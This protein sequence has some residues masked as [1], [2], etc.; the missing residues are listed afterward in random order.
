MAALDMPRLLIARNNHLHYVFRLMSQSSLRGILNEQG[1][2][3]LPLLMCW[4][5][6]GHM[7]VVPLCMCWLVV[8]L[9]WNVSMY[10]STSTRARPAPHAG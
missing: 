7:D 10:V 6:A 4:S 3:V 8:Q 9:D 5:S 2:C 1:V